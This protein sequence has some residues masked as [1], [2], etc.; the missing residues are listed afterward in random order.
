M[1]NKGNT[2]L[3]FVCENGG[4][5]GA[6]DTLLVLLV[7]GGDVNFANSADAKTPIMKVWLTF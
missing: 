1:T 3:H 2:P 4:E 7:A 6:Y 5:F